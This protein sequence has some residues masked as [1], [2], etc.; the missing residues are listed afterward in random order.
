LYNAIEDLYLIYVKKLPPGPLSL[1]V[2][3]GLYLLNPKQPHL[4]LEKLYRKY[5]PIFSL[6][7]GTMGRVIII[8]DKDLLNE[9]F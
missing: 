9:V 7:M 3:G 8:M 6:R 2:L 1:P 5:G 4:S